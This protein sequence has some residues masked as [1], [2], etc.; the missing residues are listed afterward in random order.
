MGNEPEKMQ[1]TGRKIPVVKKDS[2]GGVVVQIEA[3]GALLGL[4]GT[5]TNEAASGVL[6][7]AILALGEKGERF[8]D[9]VMSMSIELEPHDAAEAMLVTQ[10]GITHAAMACAAQ[11]M[12]DAKIVTVREPYERSMT[13]LSRTYLAQLE[14]LKKYRAKAQ[15]VV[16]VERV[17]VNEGGQAVVGDVAY[18]GGAK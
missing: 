7:S 15:Q 9:M 3:E 6:E 13:R 10:M 16:R 4:Y 2:N 17:T 11:R 12:M 8:R 1:G 14:A 5:K 18:G